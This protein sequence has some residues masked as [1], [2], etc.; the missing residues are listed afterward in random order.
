MNYQILFSA[1]SQAPRYILAAIAGITVILAFTPLHPDMPST[2][3]DPSWAYAIN[4]AVALGLSF[5]REFIFSLGPYAAIYTKVYHPGTDSIALFGGFLI[6]ICS[7]SLL[8]LLTRGTSLVWAFI[9]CV[10][11]IALL[12][13]RDPLFFSYPLLLTLAIYRVTLPGDNKYSIYLPKKMEIPFAC[14]LLPLGLLSLIKGSY[15]IISV[16]TS[17]LSFAVF[18]RIERK[19]LAYCSLALPL[20]SAVLFWLLSGQSILDIP[21]YL[22]NMKE[23]VS[24]YTE[25]MAAKGKIPGIAYYLVAVGGIFY[26]IAT[27]KNIPKHSKA[28]L[29]AGI[30]SILFLAFK[31]GF[32]RY[33]GHAIMAS[34]MIIIVATLLNLVVEHR[35]MKLIIILCFISWL[36]T[37]RNFIS[38]ST[39]MVYTSVKDF[40]KNAKYG[41]RDRL[42]RDDVLLTR[43]NAKNT[44]IKQDHPLPLLAGT[45]DIYSYN[46]SYLI[47]SG[48]IWSPRPVFQSYSAYTPELAKINEEHLYSDKGADNIIFKVAPIDIRLPALEDGRSWPVIINN[49]APVSTDNG[50]LFLKKKGP[51]NIHADLPEIYNNEHLLGTTVEI[52]Y[53]SSSAIYAEIDIEQTF[54]GRLLSFL[55]KPQKLSITLEMLS[56][57]K[58]TYQMISTMAKSGFIISPL[59]ADTNDFISLFYQDMFPNRKYVKSI[60]IFPANGN[61]I[62]WRE[63]ISIKLSQLD[64]PDNDDF[65]FPNN[66]KRTSR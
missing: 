3:L 54:I 4:E 39:A 31:G 5:G 33:D 24:G 18:W 48:N 47:A 34:T 49:Y 23:I 52:P 38:T 41:I 14:L 19:L 15:L 26:I 30:A 63:T 22:L 7:A 56:G 44:S 40:Y 17:V 10:I 55:Y 53:Y 1:A 12:Y 65:A 29:F 27:L 50:F 25:A 20:V 16:L 36:Y 35:H 13:V 59:I 21:Y 8:L 6:G 28:F 43:F 64:L 42:S 58:I 2:G 66:L 60:N 51:A 61:S 57:Q 11:I 37:D 46:Q 9:F 62:F 32:V 45:T